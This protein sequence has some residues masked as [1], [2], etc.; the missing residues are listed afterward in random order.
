M[1]TI[2]EK[3][4]NLYKDFFNFLYEEHNLICTIE[5]MDEIIHE[6]QLFIKQFDKNNDIH[7]S[8]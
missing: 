5:E 4:I 8:Q 2:A 3:Y 1:N 6:A 7:I